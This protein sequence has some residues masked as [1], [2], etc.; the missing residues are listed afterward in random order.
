[1]LRPYMAGPTL[2]AVGSWHPPDG[3]TDIHG[4]AACKF[5]TV[6][7]IIASIVP[8]VYLTSVTNSVPKVPLR[9]VGASSRSLPQGLC[10][11]L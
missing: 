1:M 7:R 10:V 9:N 3:K 5:C 4:M 11:D 8:S 6:C 2:V